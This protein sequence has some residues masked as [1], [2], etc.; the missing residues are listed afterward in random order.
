MLAK[1]PSDREWQ[2]PCELW[3]HL[4][5]NQGTPQPN[6]S[7]F[8]QGQAFHSHHTQCIGA[9]FC[10]FVNDSLVEVG[11]TVGDLIS[12]GLFQI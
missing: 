1:I 11:C 5:H 8:T 3:S 4:S 6:C 10:V 9:S 7:C 12:Q 2:T